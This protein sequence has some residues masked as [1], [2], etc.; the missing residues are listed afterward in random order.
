V[1]RSRVLIVGGGV[2]GCSLAFYLAGA[3]QDVVLLERATIAAEASGAAAGMLAPVAESSLPGPFLD[4]AIAGLRAFQEDAQAI[5]A[6]SGL[7]IAYMPVGIVRTASGVE[8]AVRLKG[9]AGWATDAGLPVRWLDRADLLHLEPGLGN[10]VLGALYSPEEAQVSPG[11]LTAALAQGAARRGAEIWEGVEVDTL[12][13]RGDAVAGVRLSTGRTLPA[14]TVL[15]TGGAWT[16]RL[17]RGVADLPV[18]PVL[19]Q[20]VLVRALPQ[21]FR[22]ILYGEHVYML[23]RPDGTIYVG[24]TEEPEQGYRKR[25]TVAGV[26]GLLNA[27]AELVP[28]IDAAEIAGTGAGLRPG[29]PDRL[30]IIGR[31]PGVEG[32]AVAAG[33]FRNGVLLSLITGRLLSEL[34]VHGRTSMDLAPF[35]PARFGGQWSGG[36]GHEALGSALGD[37]E[38]REL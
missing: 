13:R 19:G 4:L 3:G 16:R 10:T 32:L 24:A 6:V 26:R 5:E 18:E 12:I 8:R 23:P 34:I 7:N 35:T 29:T 14:D 30:P 27:A 1:A 15:L 2:V 20:Y 38:L 25:V 17:A 31:V 33:H 21:P 9:C 36:N 37:V 28:A 22:R 11:R